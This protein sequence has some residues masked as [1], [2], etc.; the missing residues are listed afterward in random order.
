VTCLYAIYSRLGPTPRSRVKASE[1]IRRRSLRRLVGPN[2]RTLL[3]REN[4]Q[5]IRGYETDV[6]GTGMID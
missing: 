6:T 4:R 2:L 3:S 1:R 5:A